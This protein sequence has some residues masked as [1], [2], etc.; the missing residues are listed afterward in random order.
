MIV[1]LFTDQNYRNCPGLSRISHV[2]SRIKEQNL[3]SSWQEDF[4]CPECAKTSSK[5]TREAEM[6]AVEYS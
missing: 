2:R 3:V 5:I 6:L 1:S 4:L